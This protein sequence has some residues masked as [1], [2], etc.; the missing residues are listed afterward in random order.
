MTD[1]FGNRCLQYH[2]VLLCHIG[3][4]CLRLILHL[5]SAQFVIGNSGYMATWR[6]TQKL[7]LFTQHG[8]CRGDTYGNRGFS[9]SIDPA[10][11]YFKWEEGLRGDLHRHISAGGFEG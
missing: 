7:T 6:A 2:R 3:H 8:G 5:L 11:R 9:K 1:A 10:V 4:H